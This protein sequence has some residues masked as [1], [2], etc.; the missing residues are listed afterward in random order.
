MD[1]SHIV[2][3]VAAGVAAGVVNAIAGGGSLITFPTLIAI[4]LP[5]VDANVTNS[6]SVSPGYV[7]SVVDSRSSD[8][9]RI[10]ARRFSHAARS[11]RRAIS[12]A[13]S[14]SARS[15]ASRYAASCS[16]ER[17]GAG[18]PRAA[19]NRSEARCGEPGVALSA[20]RSV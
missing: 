15:I 3:L 5:S 7:S 1:L 16:A 17:S 14:R 11:S 2:L 18:R 19:M 6:V 20:T 10:D 4:G 12:S 13:S 8:D 9:M